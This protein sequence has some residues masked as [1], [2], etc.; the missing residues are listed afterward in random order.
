MMT[1]TQEKPGFHCFGYGLVPVQALE[2]GVLRES[3]TERE[4]VTRDS[5]IKAKEFTWV[6]RRASQYKLGDSLVAPGEER[7]P[8]VIGRRPPSRRQLVAQH[9]TQSHAGTQDKLDS[10]LRAFE[11]LKPKL[12]PEKR[13]LFVAIHHG[14]VIGEDLDEFEL[15]ARVEDEARREGP[16]AICWVSEEPHEREDRDGFFTMFD[17]PASQEWD[18]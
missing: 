14:K 16:I 11:A 2:P 9:S 15:G 18:S 4:G 1:R 10:E 13:G 17:S 12:L 6:L 5:L 3:T 7:G 8:T